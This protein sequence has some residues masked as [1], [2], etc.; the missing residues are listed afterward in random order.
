M[1]IY[2]ISLKKLLFNRIWCLEV[3]CC[4]KKYLKMLSNFEIGQWS[5][6][7]KNIK[8]SRNNLDCFE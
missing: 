1:I 5:E 6:T 3:V 2:Y 4:S 8:N 7:G